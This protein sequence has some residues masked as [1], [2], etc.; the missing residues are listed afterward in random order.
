M[1]FFAIYYVTQKL[2]RILI[3]ILNLLIIIMQS[4]WTK[5]NSKRNI[6][7]KRNPRKAYWKH[8]SINFIVEWKTQYCQ[9][10]H[11]HMLIYAFVTKK[12]LF[13]KKS[14][15]HLLAHLLLETSLAIVDPWRNQSEM[16]SITDQTTLNL[17]S[18]ISITRNTP[19]FVC[20]RQY[21]SWQI[22]RYHKD[23]GSLN[24][25]TQMLAKWLQQQST[26]LQDEI[27]TQQRT[28]TRWVRQSLKHLF[29]PG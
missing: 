21:I 16:A 2:I 13:R 15:L 23:T 18:I 3:L 26:L 8:W 29:R 1:N 25:T 12:N 17:R 24:G 10:N 28:T 11:Y 6:G 4:W 19:K 5:I 20:Q 22:W 9:V 7:H 27:I 14:Q